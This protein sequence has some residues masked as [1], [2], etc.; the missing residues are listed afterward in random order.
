MTVVQ[1]RALTVAKY[2]FP[3]AEYDYLHVNHEV[4]MTSST[5]T[6]VN[7]LMMV[8]RVIWNV[9]RASVGAYALS[10]IGFFGLRWLTGETLNF[11]ALI[12]NMLH[13]M[14]LPALV[15]F[16]LMLV[17][18]RWFLAVVLTLPFAVAVIDNAPLFIDS[19][20]AA[21]DDATEVTVLTYNLLNR[22]GG[23][24]AFADSIAII[25]EADADVVALQEV[26]WAAYEALSVTF[27]EDYP[28]QALH[29]R[30]HGTRGSGCAEPL[31]RHRRPLLSE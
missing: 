16:P 17:F 21:P 4:M 11:V 29:P 6:R 8:L 15:L 1:I 27:A 24:D 30:D 31:S 22:S 20:G 13:L 5:P 10:L 9:F 14:L 19:A 25:R 18:R 26:S 2:T 23:V 12:N 3:L 28:H 7:P